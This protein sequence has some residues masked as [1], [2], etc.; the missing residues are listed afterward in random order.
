M[1]IKNKKI[2]LRKLILSDVEFISKNA[3]NKDV[4]K[5]TYVISPPFD[6]VVAKKFIKKTQQEMRRKKAYEFG[7]ELRGKEELI[8]TTNLFNINYKNKNADLG[9]W[10]SKK[11]WGKGLAEEALNLILNFGFKQLKLKRIQARVLHKNIRAQKLLENSGFKY[12]GRLRKKT[13]FKNKWYDDLI[14]G[15]LKEEYL[16]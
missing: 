7:I 11:Y 9:I 2:A 4:T 15:I 16:E 1:Y 10:L 5:Y 8:G 13:F 6:L 3:K 12:E 14:Y